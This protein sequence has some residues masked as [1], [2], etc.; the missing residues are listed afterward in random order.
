[1]E[2]VL[3]LFFDKTIFQDFQAERILF[4]SFF[5]EA[6]SEGPELED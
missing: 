3:F 4:I 6:G 1:M 5:F 2:V